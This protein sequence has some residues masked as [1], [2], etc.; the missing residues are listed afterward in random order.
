MRTTEPAI[1]PPARLP[2]PPILMATAIALGLGLGKVAGEG[3]NEAF[4]TAA[5]HALGIVLIMMSL[6]LDL[7]CARALARS[8]TTI[9]P[10]RAATSLVTEGPYGFSRNPIYIAH[11]ALTLGLGLLLAAPFVVALVPL[12]AAGLQKLSIEPEERHLQDKFGEDY[13]AYLARTPRWL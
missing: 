1:E 12:L 8:D 11:I 13:H 9:L 3:L 7:W 2:W 6:T 5:L 10:H 4:D